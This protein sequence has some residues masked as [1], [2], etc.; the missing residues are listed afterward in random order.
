MYVVWGGSL[1]FSLMAPDEIEMD[2]ERPGA[3]GRPGLPTEP[4]WRSLLIDSDL[5]LSGDRG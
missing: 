4:D 5:G 1:D 3:D 2:L